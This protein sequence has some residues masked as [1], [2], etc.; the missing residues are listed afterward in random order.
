MTNSLT[1]A[2]FNGVAGEKSNFR[3][4]VF[5]VTMEVKE[6]DGKGTYNS[7]PRD[8]NCFK[9]RSNVPKQICLV[10]QQISSKDS[11][12]EVERCFGVLVSPGQNV[13]DS[14]MRLLELVNN[15]FQS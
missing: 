5:E 2:D 7:V 6:E 3:D 4:F 13:K 9:L 11:G 8:R 14:D 15:Y 10:I 1:G 12:V